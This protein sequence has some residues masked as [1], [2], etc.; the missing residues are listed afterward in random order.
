MPELL[1]NIGGKLQS[2]Y[3]HNFVIYDFI[4][5][6]NFPALQNLTHLDCSTRFS[7]AFERYAMLIA[8]TC[9]SLQTIKLRFY[10][11][12]Y[13]VAPLDFDALKGVKFPC[14]KSMSLKM[15]QPFQNIEGWLNN[16]PRLEHLFLKIM[17]D[18]AVPLLRKFDATLLKELHLTDLYLNAWEMDSDIFGLIDK[19]AGSLRWLTIRVSL[20]NF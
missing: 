8:V 15:E 4:T 20:M 16:C 12:T 3:V 14:L 5:Y 19:T 2:L 17:C 1:Q 10:D 9:N 7:I 6:S 11:E 13:D 18:E